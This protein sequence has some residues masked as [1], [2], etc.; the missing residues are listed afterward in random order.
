V[1]E[2]IFPWHDFDKCSIILDST[3]GTD[4]FLTWQD[5]SRHIGDM[6]CTSVDLL[7]I[8]TAHDHF[9]IVLDIDLD[10]KLSDQ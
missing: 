10:A 9:S 7:F 1:N 4:K 6:E 3:Y 2:P 8:Y 5:L